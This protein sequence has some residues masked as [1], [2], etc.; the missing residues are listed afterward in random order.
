MSSGPASPSYQTIGFLRDFGRQFDPTGKR[1]LV[2][3]PWETGRCDGWVNVFGPAIDQ[4][5]GFV[6]L[7]HSAGEPRMPP[8]YWTFNVFEKRNS[9]DGA[10]AAFESVWSSSGNCFPVF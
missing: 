1:F 8:C 5:M 9:A 7:Q 3:Y 4:G 2:P 10:G 6:V